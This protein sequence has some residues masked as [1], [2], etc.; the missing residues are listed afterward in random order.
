MNR[1]KVVGQRKARTP[2]EFHALGARLD[3]ELSVVRPFT[4]KR[5]FI[6]KART[7]DGLPKG[8]WSGLAK[9]LALGHKERKRF[10]LARCI[11]PPVNRNPIRFGE[12]FP[13]VQ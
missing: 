2:A 8:K 5:G 12:G 4:R 11:E 1:S 7:W 6:F 3:R 9:E 10:G 13:I